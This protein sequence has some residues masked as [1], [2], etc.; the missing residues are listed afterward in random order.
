MAFSN[1]DLVFDSPTNNFATLN[2]LAKIGSTVSEGNLEVLGTTDHYA[3]RSTLGVR[4][5]KWYFETYL[6]DAGAGAIGVMSSSTAMSGQLNAPESAWYRV[7]GY[8]YPPEDS[9]GSASAD[10]DVIGC[11]FNVDTGTIEFF[12]NNV[13]MGTLGSEYNVLDTWND[14]VHAAVK[15]S[16][17]NENMVVNFGQDPTFGGNKVPSGGTNSDGSY[18]DKSTSGIGG[19]FYEPPA[20][21]LALCTANLPEMTPTVNNDTPQDYFKTVLYT[22]DGSNNR[23]ITS[24]GFQP[25]L[26]WLKARN[27]SYN[28]YLYDAV[29]G[30]GYLIL[31]NLTLGEQ[32]QTTSFNSFDS[33]GFTVSQVVGEEANQS[34][35][36]YVAWCFRAGGSPSADDTAMVDGVVRTITGDA[37]LDAGTITP[38]RMSVNTKAGFSIVQWIGN[39]QA[40]ATIP[41]GLNAVPRLIILKC[42]EV[43]GMHWAVY[44]PDT[45]GIDNGHLN[46]H[47]INGTDQATASSI[48]WSN[49]APTSSVFTT[50][51]DAVTGYTGKKF[52]GY[53]WSEVEGYSKFGSYTG[54]NSA[55]GPFVYCGFRPAFVIIK[56]YNA[57]GYNWMMYD[58]SRNTYNPVNEKLY[59]NTFTTT[60]TASDLDIDFLSNGFKV[61]GNSLGLNSTGSFIFIAFAE[62]P[63]I[64]SNAR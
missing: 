8:K 41:H 16:D 64:Y 25:D 26:V 14:N 56:R 27:Q 4:S 1:H 21:A 39:Q 38:I 53:I 62:Q 33:D 9:Y 11:L 51:T 47:I 42:T 7:N 3:V 24:V 29:R 19:F 55:D 5:G 60:V 15:T 37:K 58:S 63:F 10:G 36:T 48:Y 6:K 44:H 13:S 57:S 12:R 40:N 49:T 35:T 59:T 52:I 32:N 54:N 46:A 30:A 20:G 22:G 28:H 43:T 18:P 45:G 34:N 50:G 31:P 17:S 2:P 23:N 61:R